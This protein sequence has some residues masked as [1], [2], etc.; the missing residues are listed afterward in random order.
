M[1]QLAVVVVV[2]QVDALGCQGFAGFVQPLRKLV[3]NGFIAVIK[4][5]HPGDDHIRC[6]EALGFLGHCV[7]IPL[8]R[9]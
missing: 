2:E 4:A 1:P 6:A 7:G 8:Q 3:Y 9:A 5:V